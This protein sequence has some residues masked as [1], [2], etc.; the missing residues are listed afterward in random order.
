MMTRPLLRSF[1]VV[2][3]LVFPASALGQSFSRSIEGSYRLLPNVTYISSGIWEGKLDIYSRTDATNPR[4][5]LIWIHGGSVAAGSKESATLSLLPYLEWGW[6]V[7]NVEH[8]LTGVTLAPAALANSLCALRWIIRNAKEYGFDTTRLVISGA[9]SGGWFAVA[10][11]L[12]VRPQGWQDG[13]P[14]AE[15]PKVA[16]IVNWYGNWDLADVLE[17]PNRKP[18]AAGWVLNLPNPLEVARSLLPLPIRQSAVRG[19]ISIHGDAD[20][21]VPYT[22][23]VRLHEALRNAGVAQTMVTIPGGKHGGF[24]R[25]E[26]QRAFAAI[27]LFLARIDLD[28][29]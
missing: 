5:T 1:V 10:A 9:S 6:N 27:Q 11:G 7:V 4:P 14:G 26:N 20:P 19:V 29:K 25:S 17:G 15:E 8:R 23:S 24:P 2:V 28:A 22:Q 12:G 18:Y 21:T 13:C 3:C 16:A